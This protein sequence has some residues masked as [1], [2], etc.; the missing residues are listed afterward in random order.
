M[1][2]VKQLTDELMASIREADS[3][4]TGAYD[5]Y[6]EDDLQTLANNAG[7][8]PPYVGVIY[9]GCFPIAPTGAAGDRSVSKTSTAEERTAGIVQLRFSVILGVGYESAASASSMDQKTKATDLL[10]AI[11]SKLLG[12]VQVNS[13]PWLF[14]GEYPLGPGDGDLEGVIFY[15]QIWEVRIPTVGN[16]P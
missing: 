9:E 3:R 12:R 5:V 10:T 8:H 11:R 4:I 14:A 7:L 15:G 6:D 16:Q 2:T 13:R 1:V